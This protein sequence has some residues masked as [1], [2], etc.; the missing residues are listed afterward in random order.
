MVVG[1]FNGLLILLDLAFLRAY[2]RRMNVVPA[3]LLLLGYGLL[4]GILAVMIANLGFDQH[5]SFAFVQL[6]AW[7]LFLHGPALGVGI[8][9]LSRT[10]NSRAAFGGAFF[11]LG[12]AVLALYAF[13]IEPRWLATTHTDVEA[14]GLRQPLRVALIADLQ[15]DQPGEYE[16]RVLAAARDAAPDLVLFT[17]DYV[18][19]GTLAEYQRA[20]DQLNRILMEVDLRPPL[21]AYAVR[22]DTE[23]SRFSMW[24]PTFTGT[25]VQALEHTGIVHNPA[26]EAAGLVLA[27]LDVGDS[28]NPDLVLPARGSDHFHVVFG[29]APDNALA[30]HGADLILAGHT[31]GGQVQLPW[32]GPVLTFTRAPRAIA[33]GGLHRL[34]HGGQIYVSRG[35]GMERGA[36]PRLRFGC[37]PELAILNLVPIQR[38]PSTGTADGAGCSRATPVRVATTNTNPGPRCIPAGATTRPEMETEG[39]TGTSMRPANGPTGTARSPHRTIPSAP[40]DQPSRRAGVGNW[41]GHTRRG[42]SGALSWRPT[43]PA[44]SK[45]STCPATSDPSGAT[46]TINAMTAGRVAAALISVS[47]S[48]VGTVPRTARSGRSH[49]CVAA[50]AR[51]TPSS[52]PVSLDTGARRSRSYDLQPHQMPTM[53]D[54]KRTNQAQLCFERG[55]PVERSSSRGPS[56]FRSACSGVIGLVPD[57]PRCRKLGSRTLAGKSLPATS[58]RI[59]HRSLQ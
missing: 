23:P 50:F 2:R 46:S 40:A 27:G 12:L 29:H 39:A 4:S 20:R 47:A 34:P 6:C 45:M 13:R 8:A 49:S 5:K 32:I 58:S 14:P 21:G 16:R 7:A 44:P 43:N 17:G 41:D 26:L 19:L 37:R 54:T 55:L 48:A 59:Q 9:W 15:T 38:V 22:G 36:A 35:I 51:L 3:G 11:S 30:G 52:A 56:A 53:A 57:T 33:A 28:R 25:A 31:H 18:Q 1:L 24:S 42:R 10:Q